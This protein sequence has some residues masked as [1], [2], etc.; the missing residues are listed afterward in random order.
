MLY[1]HLHTGNRK[2]N[3]KTL[4]AKRSTLSEQSDALNAIIWQ[5]KSMRLDISERG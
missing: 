2:E 4:G 3:K 5:S 1:T